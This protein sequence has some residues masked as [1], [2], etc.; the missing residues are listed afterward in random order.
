MVA[1][2]KP[3]AE[4]PVQSKPSRRPGWMDAITAPLVKMCLKKLGRESEDRS[5]YGKHCAKVIR[6]AVAE[7]VI[8]EQDVAAAR[9]PQPR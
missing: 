7:G 6:D 4:K 2:E 1:Q 5:E 3:A 9:A 8:T